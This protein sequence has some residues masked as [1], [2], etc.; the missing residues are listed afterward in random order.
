MSVWRHVT[1]GL[2][3][4]VHRSAADRDVAD[5]VQHYYDETAAALEH[6]GLSPEDARRAARIELGQVA[7]VQQQVRSYGWEHVLETAAADVRYGVR[8]LWRRPAFATIAVL[9]LGLGIG[10]S[11]TIFSVVNPIL[12]RSLPYPEADRLMMIEDGQDGNP[13]VTFGTYREVIA[14]TRTFQS[15]AAMRP[16]QATLTSVADPE[17]LDGQYVSANYFDVL[18]VAPAIG[19]NFATADDRPGAPFVVIIT[20]GLWRRRFAADPTIVGRQVLVEDTPVTVIGVLPAAFENTLSP[21]AEIWSPLQYDVALPATGREW[22]RS[23]RMIGRLRDG[24]SEEQARR[25]LD[26]IA[27]HRVEEFSRPAWAA[28]QDGFIATTLQSGVSRGV[29]PTLVAI[30]GAVALLLIIAC[31]NV[32]NL[33]LARGA[34]RRAELMM[35]AALGASRMRLVRQLLVETLLLATMGGLVGIGLAYVAVDVVVALSPADLPRAAAISVDGWVLAFAVALVTGCGLAVGVVPA[36]QGS[37]VGLRARLHHGVTIVA[38]G[39]EVMRRVLVVVQVAFALVLLVGAGLL[40]RSLQQLFAVPSGFDAANVLTLQVQTAGR[41]F[42][43]PEP[44]NQFFSQVLDAV[45]RVPGVSTAG[46][47]TQL[48]LSGDDDM[49]GVLF[50]SAPAIPS[51]DNREAYRYAVSSGYL[52]TMR[53]PLRRGRLLGAQDQA[54]TPLVAVISESFAKRRLPGIDPIGHRL[55][56]GGNPGWFTVVGVVGDVRQMS[57]TLA[58]RNAVY[59]PGAQWS[60]FADRAHWVTVR[61]KGDAGALTASVRHAIESIDK[62]QPI[63]RVATMEE[64]VSTSEAA[65][66][67]AMMLFEAFG[68]VAL[69]LATVGTYSLLSASVTQRVREIAVRAALGAGRRTLLALVLR[70]G[71]MLTMAGILAGLGIALIAS[72]FVETMLFGVSRL[73]A[74]TY[75]AVGALLSLTC[76]VACWMPAWRAA[77][78]DP[79]AVL[80]AD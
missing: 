58:P 60:Q 40:M 51:D 12:L 13:Q 35:R 10:A 24:V 27:R 22:G 77:R 42:R 52:E 4:L 67:F 3:T 45:R 65:R 9:T 15:L 69:V 68:I 72:R 44:T 55:R 57:L 53:I 6:T 73:D 32:T 29:R 80:R 8:Q 36:L 76:A 47:T 54:N 28:I 48:P 56:I 78:L 71:M 25:D 43:D 21:S 18:G 63:L 7:S 19:R 61:T 79:N 30:L 5:E 20:D 39:R 11:T 23:L 33:V 49:W 74:V 31:V 66:R 16:L 38:A 37:R 50:D 26:A 64:R 59:I 46:V 62:R 34:E 1:R 17:R 75:I 41:R 2:R 14:R 70:Q